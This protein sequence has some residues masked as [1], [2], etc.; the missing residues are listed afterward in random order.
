MELNI[1]ATQAQLDK[2]KSEELKAKMDAKL[3]MTPEELTELARVGDVR[4]ILKNL[5]LYVYK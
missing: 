4:E 3:K 1:P 5:L 2:I